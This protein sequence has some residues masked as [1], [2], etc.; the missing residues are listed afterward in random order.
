[1]PLRELVFLNSFLIQ[2]I[3]LR[4]QGNNWTNLVTFFNLFSK[5]RELRLA[6]EEIFLEL[7][8]G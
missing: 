3:L 2:G 8:K 4:G 1:M 6:N 5:Q 7:D